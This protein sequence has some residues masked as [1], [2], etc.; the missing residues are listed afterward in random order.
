MNSYRS[1]CVIETVFHGSGEG[2]VCADS[3]F[4]V[5]NSAG[6]VVAGK[7]EGRALRRTVTMFVY[8]REAEIDEC[9]IP[10]SRAE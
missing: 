4:S 7:G 9:F 2:L 5:G 10:A 8:S 6:Q 3:P 1:S